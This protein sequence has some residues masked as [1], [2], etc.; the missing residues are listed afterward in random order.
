V[1]GALVLPS[2]LAYAPSLDAPFFFDDRP[3]IVNNASVTGA[4]LRPSDLWRAAW[5][6]PLAS[7]PLPYATFA[8]NW[9][10]DGAA[11]FHVVNLLIHVATALLV[12]RFY[13]FALDPP[14]TDPASAGRLA[15]LG[16]ALLWALSPAHTQ[17]VAYIVQRMTS[18]MAF[19]FMGALAAFLQA[20]RSRGRRR[21]ACQVAGVAFGALAV[22]SKELA[23]LLPA[24]IVLVR[25]LIVDRGDGRRL[26]R[27]RGH[28]RRGLLVASVATLLIGLFYYAVRAAGASDGVVLRQ[29]AYGPVPA[30]E[31]LLSFGRIIGRYVSWLLW[32]HPSRMNVDPEF[33]TSIGPF[34]PPETLLALLLVL[35]AVATAVRL[36]RRAPLV[37]LG[38]LW[39]VLSLVP[40][41]TLLRLD[42]LFEHRL[43]LPSIGFFL[44]FGVALRAL[45]R[46][47]RA[48]RWASLA[49]A[50]ALI[51]TSGVWCFERNV[52][53][54]D[55]IR[56]WSESAERSPGKWRPPLNLGLELARAGRTAEAE[57][58][59][60]EA[61][62]RGPRR[63]DVMDELGKL[64]LGAGR[65]ESAEAV[66]LE[67]AARVSDSPLP[68]LMIAVTRE[69]T[70]DGAG[71]L[72]ALQRAEACAPDRPEIPYR[73]GMLLLADGRTAAAREAFDRAL[74]I[75]PEFAPARR[76]R[77]G[78]DDAQAI[79]EAPPGAP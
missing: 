53:W 15:A 19:G 71:V 30:G 59:L 49:A 38:A 50:G 52:A 21:T 8:F 33:R 62:R 9:V 2:I 58:A 20:W 72:D 65:V 14:T 31:R 35:A 55:P 7:R 40:E 70:G 32:P 57:V 44:L 54:S 60:R 42:L 29:Y 4:S 22:G 79:G 5:K 12:Y 47:G 16:G 27:P 3:N 26:G 74:R 39:F 51:A 76:A 66:Y 13:R 67:A 25:R 11:G 17:A 23:I 75:A 41:H 6:S 10:V 77:E 43:Y 45:L 28:G 34:A 63:L 37:T 36:A 46:R 18:L 69:R 78:I 64:L 68:W 1:A 61:W 73:I 48:A 56:L 24:A